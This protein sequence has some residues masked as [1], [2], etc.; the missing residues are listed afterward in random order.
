MAKA[1]G[2][3]H[4]QSNKLVLVTSGIIAQPHWGKTTWKCTFEKPKPSVCSRRNT[5][6]S[7]STTACSQFS[8]NAEAITQHHAWAQHMRA[9]GWSENIHCN[10]SA[11]VHLLGCVEIVSHL[12]LSQILIQGFLNRLASHQASS[13]STTSPDES[14]PSSNLKSRCR[15]E[16]KYWAQVQ[17]HW[18]VN[19]YERS[20]VYVILLMDKI[21][22]QFIYGMN[23]NAF[24]TPICY[25]ICPWTV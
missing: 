19:S 1:L 14:E 20:S 3:R 21:S 12:A 18:S 15:D 13:H 24:T 16:L 8:K 5:A 17:S 22:H 25:R 2:H 10:G 6:A 7:K 9:L 11:Y 4:F 23:W